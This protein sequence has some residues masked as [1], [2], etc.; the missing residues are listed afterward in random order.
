VTHNRKPDVLPVE[1]ASI[2]EALEAL[3]SF[4]VRDLDEPGMDSIVRSALERAAAEGE[5]RR[6]VPCSERMPDAGEDVLFVMGGKTYAG[7]GKQLPYGLFFRSLAGDFAAS[8]VSHWMPL[9]AL[10]APPK[11]STP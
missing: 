9:S 2:A 6:W 8:I 7:H 5:A 10:P 1:G 11:G 3:D 4:G